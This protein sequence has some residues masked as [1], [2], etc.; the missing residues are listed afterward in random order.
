[1]KT[2]HRR[3]QA[4][5]EAVARRVAALLEPIEA[6]EDMLVLAGRDAGPIIGDRNH[7]LAVHDIAGNDDLAAG[8]AML[9]R[10]VDEIG[11]GIEDQV[12]VARREHLAIARKCQPRAVLLRRGIVQFDDL[13]CNLDQVDG[14]EAALAGLGLDLRDAHD[15]RKDAQH[16]IEIGDGV[17]DQRLVALRRAR[18]EI[19]LLEP[20]AHPRQRRPQIMRDIVAD[21]LDL[22]HQGLDAVQHLVQV[23]GNA[24]PFVMAAAQGDALVEAAGHDGATGGVDLLDPSHGAAGH[25]HARHGGKREDQNGA[26]DD[27]E[28]DRGRK[29]VEVADIQPGQEAVA[30]RKCLHDRAQQRLARCPGCGPGSAKFDPSCGPDRSLRPLPEIAGQHVLPWVDEQVDVIG[31]AWVGEVPADQRHQAVAPRAFIGFR[32]AR[33]LG[34]D[35][36]VRAAADIGGGREI[37]IGEDRRRDDAKGADRDQR[38]P[39]G[40]R[41][42]GLGQQ[43]LSRVHG[44]DT[45]HR[46]PCG[47]ADRPAGRRPC[48]ARARHRR[49]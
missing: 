38:E 37:D 21:L 15:G 34:G 2:S 4:E 18:A 19:G 32:Q 46:G 33:N 16:G 9:E 48:D 1:M 7:R 30:V 43:H 41:R 45:R 6:L 27:G 40:R 23:F 17:A 3:D 20:A 47:S 42:E 8:A 22:A 31:K 10:I 11:D 5:T 13:A 25:Q 49:R 36:A 44:G 12:A 28:L 24:V 39:K 29:T 35:L 14:A 26:G